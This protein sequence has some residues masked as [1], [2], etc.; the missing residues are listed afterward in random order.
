MPKQQ[1]STY[2]DISIMLR[3][4]CKVISSDFYDTRYYD[5][6]FKFKT[7]IG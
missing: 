3:S 7:F 4:D 5:D 1:V 6:Y 2:K